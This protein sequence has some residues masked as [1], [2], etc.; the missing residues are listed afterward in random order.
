MVKNDAKQ[1]PGRE[2]AQKPRAFSLTVILK[3]VT[4]TFY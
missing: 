2:G 4:I 1:N 3:L